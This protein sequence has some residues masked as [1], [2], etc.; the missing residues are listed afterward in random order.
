M[1]KKPRKYNPGAFI[2]WLQG[3][4][5]EILPKTNDFEDVRWRGSHVG[6]RYTSGKTNGPYA[7]RAIIAFVKRQKWDGGPVRTGRKK[8]YVKQKAHILKRD[9]SDCFFCGL[10]LGDDITV[11]HLIALT[12][13]GPNALSNMVLAH[14]DCNAGAHTQD[15]AVKVRVA[16]E[17]RVKLLTSKHNEKS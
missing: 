4:G 11:E 12:R 5:C 1:P 9:G 8:S 7:Y 6:V 16:I 17:N 15:V 2:S 3:Y 14:E 10:P 13:G